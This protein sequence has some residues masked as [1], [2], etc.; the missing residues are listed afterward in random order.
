MRTVRQLPDGT[1]IDDNFALFPDGTVINETDTD[2]GTPVVR[3]IYGDILTNVYRLL[4]MAGITASGTEDSETS[5]Y[6]LVQAL[7]KLTNVLNDVEQQLSQT[8]SV[9]SIG[10]DLNFLP[11]KYVL[12]TRAVEDYVTGSFTFKGSTA[13]PTY[14]FSSPTGFKSG[15]EVILVLDHG[16]VRAYGIPSLTVATE[17]F[18]PFGTPLAFNNSSKVWYQS[19]GIL[20]SDLPE[21][22][23]LQAAIRTLAGDGTMLVY[24]MLLIGSY[25]LCLAYS[26][27]AQHYAF[28]KFST[29][30]LNTPTAVAMVGG[31][32]PT[33]TD[34][35]P[36]V[37]T[38]GNTL[39]ISNSTGNSANNYAQD[40]Y[41]LD[42]A[43]VGMTKTGSINL[44]I[45]FDKTTNAV[46]NTG[47][48]YTF[49]AGQLVQ[50]NLGTGARV[51]GPSFPGFT[52]VVFGFN[53][54][55]Y[56]SNGEVAKK[57]SLP[58]YS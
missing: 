45:A 46:I 39:Y 27:T 18:T 21:A 15:D 37:Y 34:N 12:V 23:D 55:N 5:Q 42:L 41:H 17:A 26:Q 7:Q 58:V 9:F 31:S 53:G 25:V 11:D 38:D 10:L 48:L 6:Q 13:T 40:I 24:E 43:T 8:G 33:G 20:F 2:P 22:Y 50:Y 29:S 30:A 3:E 52:G 28:Y 51:L 14:G 36:N 4:R 32:F 35:K 49:V 56:H 19:E 57:W 44:N 1:P 54:G 47:Y 16:G